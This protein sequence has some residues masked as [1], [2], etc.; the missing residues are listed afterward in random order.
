[1]EKFYF[2]VPTINRKNDA[3]EFIQEF[4][5]YSSN[6]YGAGSL[7]RY[8]DNYEGWL[9]KLEQDYVREVD[10]DTSPLEHISLLEVAIKE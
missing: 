3:L 4:F 8:V 7:K 10:E 1:M 2:E 9:E 5:D 6:V